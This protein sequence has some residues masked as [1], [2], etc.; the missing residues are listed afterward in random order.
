MARVKR[1]IIGE[2]NFTESACGFVFTHS[3]CDLS[4][5]EVDEADIRVV[6]LLA[7]FPGSE[8]I[9]V[10]DEDAKEEKAAPEKKQE[11]PPADEKPSDDATGGDPVE[12][13]GEPEK[14]PE[15]NGEAPAD[16]AAEEPAAEVAPDAE[17]DAS[18]EADGSLHNSADADAIAEAVAVD[19]AAKAAA[20]EPQEEK[21]TVDASEVG[22]ISEVLGAVTDAPAEEGEKKS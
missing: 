14:A 17:A 4:D 5:Q 12:P 8:V 11:A 20:D 15:G 22:D 1:L 9:L 2:T 3:V 18:A 7:I 21:Q 13:A 6:R 10:G 19:E 16:D